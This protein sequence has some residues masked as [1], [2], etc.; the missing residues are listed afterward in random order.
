MSLHTFTFNNGAI[1]LVDP[2]PNSDNV[3][4]GYY[5]QVGARYERPAE[6]G[7][8]H[9]LEHMA[10]KGTKSRT[11]R[12]LALE[13]DDLAATTNAFTSFDATCYYMNG[14]SEDVI[15]FND[16]LGDI[17]LNLT[18]PADELEIERGA[19]IEE[20]GRAGDDPVKEAYFNMLA[21]AYPDQ[22]S[23]QTVLGPKDNIKSF[24]RAD[25]VSFLDRHYHG[26]NL[27]VSVAGNVNPESVA[28]AV[29]Q[30]AGF[31]PKKNPS[32]CS[33]P[34]YVGGESLTIQPRNQVNLLVGFQSAA[35]GTREHLAETVLDHVL[36]TGMSSRLFYEVREKRGLVYTVSSGI[37]ESRNAG[38]FYL[39]AGT[40]P[41]KVDQLMPVMTGELDKLRQ[42][43]IDD[44]ELARAV[45]RVKVQLSAMSDSAGARMRSNARA[46]S[47]E[48]K[49]E[50]ADQIMAELKTIT[51]EEVQ[52][53]AQ[54]VFSTTPTLSAVG[55]KGL[56]SY[57]QVTN[58]LTP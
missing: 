27:I 36:G 41:E 19:I 33:A 42:A 7:L 51:P 53:A 18:L 21:A 17:A 57:D 44:R 29:N 34:I 28:M 45:R 26:G 56:P 16:I 49:V 39:Y 8:A 13:A 54:R 14:L 50:T 31:L 40:S 5:F 3:S 25:F 22:P 1:L 35:A 55:P 47:L 9:F 37:N 58:G 30:N 46:F 15:K 6:N 24:Q 43:K 38:M 20:I 12:D 48:G 11:A 2:M 4:L 52:A 10:F 23:G 32:T